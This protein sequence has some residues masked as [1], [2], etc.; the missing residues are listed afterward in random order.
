MR[1]VGDLAAQAVAYRPVPMADLPNPPDYC[2]CV[3]LPGC[4]GNEGFHFRRYGKADVNAEID[5]ALAELPRGTGD[6]DRSIV[7]RTVAA[8]YSDY[9]GQHVAYERCPAFLAAVERDIREK[10]NGNG[11]RNGLLGDDL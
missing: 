4:W 5:R 9:L 10:R 6:A 7:E 3:K 11:H 8:R 2:G 1:R